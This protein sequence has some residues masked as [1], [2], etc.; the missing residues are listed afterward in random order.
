MIGWNFLQFLQKSDGLPKSQPGFGRFNMLAAL[1]SW[2]GVE[3]ETKWRRLKNVCARRAE[4]RLPQL[5][6]SLEFSALKESQAKKVLKTLGTCA[7][8]LEKEVNV[9]AV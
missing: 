2:L 8:E 3:P 4:L 5:Y 1:V 7:Q 9:V 6:T